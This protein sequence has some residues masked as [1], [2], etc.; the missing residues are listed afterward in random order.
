MIPEEGEV[1]ESAERLV[2]LAHGLKTTIFV[3]N[4]SEFAGELI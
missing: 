2:E 4:A 3:R 1:A